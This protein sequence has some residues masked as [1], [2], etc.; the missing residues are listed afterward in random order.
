MAAT[1]ICDFLEQFQKKG[2]TRFFMP[3]H[4]GRPWDA[5]D[6]LSQALP[7]DLTE[8]TGADALFSAGGIIRQSEEEASRLFET[9]FTVYSAG[10]S[11]LCIQA[12][13]AL[14]A[15]RGRRILAG[16]NAHMAFL[17]A[18]VLLGLEPVWM[19]PRQADA[20]GVCGALTP[21]QVEQGLLDNPDIKTVYLTCPDYLGNTPDLLEIGKIC[22]R[23]GAWLLV[24]NAHGAYLKFAGQG[25]HP[26]ELGA[27]LCCDSA[28]KTLPALTGAAY[29]HG[30][31]GCGVTAGEVKEAM[32]WFGSSSPSYLILA[33]LDRC[34]QYLETRAREDFSAL[35][36]RVEHTRSLLVQQGIPFL[37]NPIDW[38]KITLD[39]AAAGWDGEELAEF[40]RSQGIE[41][42][43]A[44]R[45]YLVYLT[46]PLNTD[47][48][49]E[50]F[51]QAVRKLS[52]RPAARPRPLPYALPEQCMA[53]REA[54]FSP[55]EEVSAGE[56]V[57]R[58]AARSVSSCPPGVP[59]VIPGEKITE[60]IKNICEKSGNLRIKVVK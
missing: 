12:M 25:R 16:R 47:S 45:E 28:H 17:H 11:T 14:A 10:G 18:C 13:A 48:D 30:G 56:S 9:Q 60:N 49:W 38:A 23:H 21:G 36:A 6:F 26:I 44:N 1:P 32:H 37:P 20:Y 27:Q 7:M 41:Q 3:G 42:E 59:V 15:R 51:W 52:P 50:R 29:L 46:S 40:F 43:Y 39:G 5:G 53:P 2:M 22:R 35:R 31:N 57:G 8:I 4:K 34:N 55:W 24:D 33:S 58:I 19:L 54:F